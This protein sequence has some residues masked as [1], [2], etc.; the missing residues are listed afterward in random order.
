MT[1]SSNAIQDTLSSDEELRFRSWTPC[2]APERK[3]AIEEGNIVENTRTRTSNETL[4]YPEDIWEKW[5]KFERLRDINA[6]NEWRH[7]ANINLSRKAIHEMKIEMM[8]AMGHQLELDWHQIYS[9]KRRMFDLDLA[10][11]GHPVAAIGFCVYCHHHDEATS[12]Y[13]RNTQMM[14]QK[15]HPGDAKPYWPHRPPEKNDDR[16]QHVAENLMS[17]HP[18]VTESSLQS[19]LQKLAAGGIGHKVGG[20]QPANSEILL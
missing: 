8:T 3:Q 14:Y 11:A 2:P 9:A 10:D 15:G 6:G 20:Y 19:I 4:F 7:H 13:E 18:N 1:T 17:F 16:F 5:E 12:E